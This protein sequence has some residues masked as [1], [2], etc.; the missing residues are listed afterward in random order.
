MKR[1]LTEAVGWFVF[2]IASGF[3]FGMAHYWGWD[4]G[5]TLLVKVLE[6]VHP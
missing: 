3:L 1:D 4:A 6:V 5:R 2:V